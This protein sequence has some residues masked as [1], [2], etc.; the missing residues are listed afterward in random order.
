MHFNCL[1]IYC[2][3]TKGSSRST[4]HACTC[5]ANDHRVILSKAHILT[6][7]SVEPI[8]SDSVHID[9]ETLCGRVPEPSSG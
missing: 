4:F 7:V 6:L 9:N 5:A 2:G 3:S 1:I 8:E